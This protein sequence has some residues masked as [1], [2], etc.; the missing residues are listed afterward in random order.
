[1]EPGRKRLY[2]I[3]ISISLVLIAGVLI[4]GGFLGSFNSSVT[5]PAPITPVTTAVPA[6]KQSSEKNYTAPAVF[7][8]NKTLDFSILD[9]GNFKQLQQYNAVKVEPTE[10]GRT[11]PFNGL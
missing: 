10:L 3:I 4:W 11:N 8:A 2:I 5:P 9:S 6:A 7:P 1:M